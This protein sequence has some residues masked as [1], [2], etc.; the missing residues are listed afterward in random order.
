MAKRL[1]IIIAGL[2]MANQAAFANWEYTR[3][4][5]TSEEIQGSQRNLARENFGGEVA[6]RG[7]FDNRHGAADVTLMFVNDKL[8]TVQL[9]QET[10]A[11]CNATSTE[12]AA[13]FGKGEQDD[14]TTMWRDTP[15]GNLIKFVD[16]TTLS[17]RPANSS[18]WI[19]FS[20]LNAAAAPVKP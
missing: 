10:Q 7:K 20:D 13:K 8:D 16:V 6:L 15:G 19:Y 3:W 18:C 2:C 14:S 5:E 11:Q 1:A 4:G 9:S 17:R 12:F